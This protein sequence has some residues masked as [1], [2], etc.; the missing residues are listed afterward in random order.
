MK[1]LLL[2]LIAVM[3]LALPA[4]A[5]SCPY[6]LVQ[7]DTATWTELDECGFGKFY[8]STDHALFMCEGFS[9]APGTGYTLIYYPDPWENGSTQFI[10]LGSG[11]ADESGYLKIEGDWNPAIPIE[12]DE[13][14]PAF[15][16]WLVTSSSIAGDTLKWDTPGDW[17]YETAP[18][19]LMKNKG[20]APSPETLPTKKCYPPSEGS[21]AIGGKICLC[22]KEL[23]T[24]NPMPFGASG[25]LNTGN[26][27]FVGYRFDPEREYVLIYYPDLAGN[28]YPHPVVEMGCAYADPCGK[29][30]IKGTFDAASQVREDDL[31]LNETTTTYVDGST[32]IKAWVVPADALTTAGNETLLAWTDPQAF[33]F[34][35]DLITMQGGNDDPVDIMN[36]LD[37]GTAYYETRPL[38]GLEGTNCTTYVNIPYEKDG[39][40]PS[41]VT[42]R[43]TAAPFMGLNDIQAAYLR[44]GQTV[45]EVVWGAFPGETIILRITNPDDDTPVHVQAK[46]WMCY[47]A[48]P[49]EYNH[50]PVTIQMPD[51]LYASSGYPI[52]WEDSRMDCSFVSDDDDTIVMDYIITFTGEYN[53]PVTV[54]NATV[55][56]N[57]TV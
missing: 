19:Q 5:I 10:A 26:W 52:Y 57:A 20:I 6:N 49:E 42:F 46:Q 3:L 21:T 4:A 28:P 29:L 45:N 18:F 25:M 23:G 53:S 8:V 30:V 24:W 48:C 56:L 41:S 11:T 32:G 54:Q 36:L 9:L 22:E 13:N 50:F 2:C 27:R 33:A 15:K 16:I 7:K 37:S 43:I 47:D 38:I 34:E 55:D 35:G 39:R 31:N 14:A 44:D 12:V 51:S 1:R 40:Y 17:L